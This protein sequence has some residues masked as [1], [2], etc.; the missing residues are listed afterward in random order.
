M[1]EQKSVCV[2]QTAAA[3]QELIPGGQSFQRIVRRGLRVARSGVG[4]SPKHEVR[5]GMD[6]EWARGRK[7]G[8]R[9]KKKSDLELLSSGQDIYA[10]V[11]PFII[12]VGIIGNCVSLRVFCSPRMRNMSA[13][14]YLASLA[15]SDTF[16]LLTYVLVE[17]MHRG[18]GRWPGGFSL[19]LPVLHPGIIII[20]IIIILYGPPAQSL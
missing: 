10:F 7:E 2:H 12:L 1:S 5:P 11:T 16:V 9:W 6:V 14:I 17:W 8:R 15:V 18:M 20:I 3:G 19:N 13:S 4:S